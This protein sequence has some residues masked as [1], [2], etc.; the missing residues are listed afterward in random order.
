MKKL[1]ILLGILAAALANAQIS[2]FDDI[3]TWAGS[4]VNRSALV[5]DWNDGVVPE[6][7]VWGFRWDG[8]A[9]GGD[10]LAAVMAA[11]PRFSR[12]MGGGGPLTIFGL[13]YDTDGNGLPL[14]GSG[15]FQTPADPLDHFR[16]GWFQS[17]YWASYVASGT[18]QL[19]SSWSFGSGDFFTDDLQDGDWKGWSWQPNFDGDAPSAPFNPPAVPEPAGLIAIAAGTLAVLRRRSRKEVG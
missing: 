5:I 13:G 2:G 15:E 19:P 11:D 9:T 18:T 3:T 1:L 7:L 12:V 8:T 10:M 16:E 4:G 17:G 6:S 14:Q